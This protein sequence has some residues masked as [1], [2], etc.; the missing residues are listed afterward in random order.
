MTTETSKVRVRPKLG[1]LD[2]N[3]EFMKEVVNIMLDVYQYML[4]NIKWLTYH[5]IF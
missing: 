4:Y 2:L 1:F 5:G 3:T